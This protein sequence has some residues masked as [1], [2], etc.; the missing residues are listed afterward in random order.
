VPGTEVAL[1]K[2]SKPRVGNMLARE[3]LF[4]SIDRLRERPVV[5]IAAEPG[6]GKTTLMA[7]YLEARRLPCIWYQ[8]DGGDADPA[9]FFYHL[10]LA[11]QAM[12]RGKQSP[13]PLP[14]LTSDRGSD[15]AGFA[16][17]Y[18]RSLY[19]RMGRGSALVLDNLHEA[20]EAS[21]LHRV[22]ATAFEEAPTASRRSSPAASSRPKST[23]SSLHANGSPSS[24]RARCGSHC[25]SRATSSTAAPSST[26]RRCGCCTTSRAA[27]PRA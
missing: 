19:G 25:R 21:P 16:R 9:T 10:G 12:K 6:A 4:E 8:V 26:T 15:L 3:R 1:A 17:L 13:A 18:F 23:C 14:L 24:S 2:L 22:L 5:W 11:A 20:G 7:S 27:G